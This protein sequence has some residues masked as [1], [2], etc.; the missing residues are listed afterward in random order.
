MNHNQIISTFN[1]TLESSSPKNYVKRLVKINNNKIIIKN[2]SFDLK[3][4]IFVLSFGK[5]S[6]SMFLGFK[7]IV[8][9]NN[10]NSS[11]IISHLDNIPKSNKKTN[12]IKSSH[13][14]ITN[15]S[16]GAGK[17]ALSFV[18]KI[19]KDAILFVLVSGGGSAM[20]SYPTDNITFE[21]KK[22]F[23]SKLLTSGTPEREVN[24]IR[25]SI[26]QIKGG[27]LAENS[28]FKNI[29]NLI[30]SDERN[31]Q[32]K[33]ISSGPTIK[34]TSIN[35]KYIINKY[36]LWSSVP[37]NLEN[38]YRSF[39]SKLN[40]GSNKNIFNF[41]VGS[42]EDFINDF[43]KILINKK[44]DKVHKVPNNFSN[45]SYKYS[46]YLSKKLKKIY[47]DAP[48]GEYVVLS[49]GEIQVKINKDL[50]AIRGGRNQHL[51]ACM[52]M[53]EEFCF[54][55]IFLAIA[56][57]GKDFIDGVSGAHY[58]SKNMNYIH[59]NKCIIKNYIKTQNTY[60]LHKKLNTLIK[61]KKTGH[62][63]S[64]IFIFYFKKI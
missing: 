54:E 53:Q 61:S 8:G 29:I 25:K 11:L 57:D 51:V 30:L 7:E 18:K 56:T 31:H 38:Y 21:D 46:L 20:M 10:I 49:S 26:S 6:I 59:K 35:P 5:A 40:R 19:P 9:L 16:L 12:F 41:L 23:L 48:K 3:K 47:A 1:K 27:G 36:S 42:R 24:E 62:N 52:M 60:K 43:S 50:K 44:I 28:G 13:P 4:N 33:A 63:V 2:K 58:G 55:F 34:T 14:Y 15:K 39:N 37:K 17:K 64:D 45:D 32:L 22:L